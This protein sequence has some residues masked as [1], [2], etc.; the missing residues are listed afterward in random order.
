MTVHITEFERE[1]RIQASITPEDIFGIALNNAMV[2]GVLKAWK[3]GIFTWE[4]AMTFLVAYLAREN[5]RLANDS[6]KLHELQIPP[7]FQVGGEI[8]EYVGPCPLCNQ[9][10]DPMK[11]KRKPA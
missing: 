8:H 11:L 7:A 9:P 3:M 1:S 6:R 5:E 2:A 4:Q 10:V